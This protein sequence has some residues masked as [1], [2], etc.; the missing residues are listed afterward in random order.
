MDPIK[1]LGRTGALGG[2]VNKFDGGV[3]ILDDLDDHWTAKHHKG[4]RNWLIQELQEFA[5]DNSVRVTI[6]SGDVHLGAVGQFFSNKALGLPKDMDHRYMPNVIS[7]AIV[8]GPPASFVADALNKDSGFTSKFVASIDASNNLTVQALDGG[9]VTATSATVASP[10][11]A[12]AGA[13]IGAATNSTT[14]GLQFDTAG[15]A[16]ASI[17]A[18]DAQLS[19]ISDAGAA[20]GA[21]ENRFNSAV[22]TINTSIT[23][24]TAA[25]SRITDVDMAQE[26]VNYTRANVLSQSGTAMLAQANSLP[27]LALKLLS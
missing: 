2:F 16:Q 21:L 18:I 5:A 12:T 9:T 17:T 11:S 7:S 13:G 22:S 25:K 14:T 15:H 27:Q 6:L 19:K 26:M 1:A 8:N 4:E 3:E 10:G 23:N 20:I 24:L